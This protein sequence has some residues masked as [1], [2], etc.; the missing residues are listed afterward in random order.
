MLDATAER[1]VMREVSADKVYASLN[2]YAEISRHGATPFIPFKSIHTGA[3]GGLWAKMFHY[4]NYNREDFLKHYSKRSNVE[5]TFS[6][7][8]AKF[9]DSLRSKTDVAMV[10]ESL[11]KLVARNFC[12]LISALYELGIVS[13]FW[14]RESDPV[15]PAVISPEDDAIEAFAGYNQAHRAGDSWTFAQ[16]IAR[17]TSEVC[18]A[19][20][21]WAKPPGRESPDRRTGR[22]RLPGVDRSR[23]ACGAAHFGPASMAGSAG[24]LTWQAAH[25]SGVGRQGGFPFF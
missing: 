8:K 1:F 10:N 15:E 24:V 5:S 7:I 2:N 3:G 4:F 12:C 6:M 21:G 22:V 23:S 17:L 25:V 19:N 16:R 11:A 14:R 9:G 13:T 20:H 18:P